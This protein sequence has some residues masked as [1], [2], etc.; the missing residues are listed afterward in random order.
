MKITVEPIKNM[1]GK[2]TGEY[3][4]VFGQW[5]SKGKTKEE[6]KENLLKGMEWFFSESDFTPRYKWVNDVVIVL[7]RDF[8]GFSIE[9]IQN[10][11]SWGSIYN[12]GSMNVRE[13]EKRY[14]EYVSQ[15]AE[16]TAPAI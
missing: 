16:A 6:A 10:G 15:Y 12:M 2:K 13:A 8:S 9:T 11:R 3:K 7:T 1:F 14:D 4:A 5:D